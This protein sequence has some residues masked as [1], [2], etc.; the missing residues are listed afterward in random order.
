MGAM[1]AIAP[2]G[3]SKV[4]EFGNN[5]A[6]GKKTLTRISINSMP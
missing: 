5:A 1:P 3:D 4:D 6:H 2:R